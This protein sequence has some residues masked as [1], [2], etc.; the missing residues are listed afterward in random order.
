MVG[1]DKPKLARVGLNISGANGN[2]LNCRGSAKFHLQ[3]G[4]LCLQK[5][6]IVADITDEVLL[7]AD[8]LIGKRN[9]SADILLSQNVMILNGT[10]IPLEQRSVIFPTRKVKLADNY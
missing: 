3:L 7:G 10:E 2:K 6:L 5:E 9:K 1:Q 4:P 8:I